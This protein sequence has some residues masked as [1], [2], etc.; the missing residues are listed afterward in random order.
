MCSLDV[1]TVSS[2]TDSKSAVQLIFF[3]LELVNF[4]K[5]IFFMKCHHIPMCI[6]PLAFNGIAFA[7]FDGFNINV[8]NNVRKH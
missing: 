6:Y 7:K 1:S 4:G 3:P 5:N 8:E 2:S